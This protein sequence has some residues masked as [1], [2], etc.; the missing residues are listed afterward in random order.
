[1]KILRT[2][3]E[4][5]FQEEMFQI[6]STLGFGG[7]IFFLLSLLLPEIKAIIWAFNAGIVSGFI[8]GG[9]TLA[10]FNLVLKTP[11][12]IT[13]SAALLI[14]IFSFFPQFLKYKKKTAF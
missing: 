10:A 13:I 2:K 7:M 3:Q 14:G 5:E 1:M 11:L 4:K 9:I 8:G 12:E 6:K